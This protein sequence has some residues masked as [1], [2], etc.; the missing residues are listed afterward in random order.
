MEGTY[1]L[2]SQDLYLSPVLPLLSG[3]VN[4]D[5]ELNLLNTVFSPIEVDNT[6]Y[7]RISYLRI[8]YLRMT[9]PYL[10]IN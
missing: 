8:N 1:I 4:L 3:R 10:R 5:K 9:Y 2:L 7:F 6:T